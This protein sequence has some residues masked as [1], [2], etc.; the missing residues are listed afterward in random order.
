METKRFIAY[1]DILG[2]KE[3]VNKN[4]IQDL[5]KLLNQLIIA[6]QGVIS[7]FKLKR[8]EVSPAYDISKSNIKCLH[9]SDSIIFWTKSDS[10]KDFKELVNTCKNLYHL[11][12]QLSIPLRGCIVYG[13][14]IECFDSI[15][16]FHCASV[17]GQGIVD[18]YLKAESLEC[19][20]C[21]VDESIYSKVSQKQ[22]DLLEKDNVLYRMNNIPRKSGKENQ[23]KSLNDFV[24]KLDVNN[25]SLSN[26]KDMI[27]T[28]F[29]YH[30]KINI[31]KLAESVKMKLK[32]TIDLIELFNT[33]RH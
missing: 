5:N 22:I 27:T 19:S 6:S 25:N 31:D 17:L 24:I 14:I 28:S 32:N 33:D 4:S 23:S 20:A 13:D 15:Y 8:T 10:E 26:I 1:F 16:N 18:A 21:I 7:N 30:Q 11:S 9:I 3:I 29:T 2:F 12:F